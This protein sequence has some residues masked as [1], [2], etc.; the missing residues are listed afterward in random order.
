MKL[1]DGIGIEVWKRGRHGGNPRKIY[2]KIKVNVKENG[3]KIENLS[4]KGQYLGMKNKFSLET[5]KIVE[6][7]YKRQKDMIHSD[8]MTSVTSTSIPPFVRCI[9]DDRSMDI[10]FPTLDEADA[11]VLYC[12]HLITTK[13]KSH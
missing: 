5:L 4:W 13:A 12:Q 2:M 1:R 3:T 8:I 7:L 10:L 11:F 6:L 9:N